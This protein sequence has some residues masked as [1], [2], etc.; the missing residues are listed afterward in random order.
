MI[1]I[2]VDNI[3]PNRFNPNVMAPEV[4]R[5]LCED[6][7][8]GGH[9][10]I[11]PITVSEKKVFYNNPEFESGK[12]VI[13]D[14]ENRWKAAKE[15][16]WS[17]IACDISALTEDLAKVV[18]YRKNKERGTIDPLREA[19]L[20]K[21]E[22][23][24]LT[25]EQVALKYGVSQPF[26]ANRLRLIKLNPEVV[27]AY[28]KPNEKFKEIQIKK[29]E[30]ELKEWKEKQPKNGWKPEKPSEEDL[31]PRGIISSSHL[32]AI[33]TLPED[34]QLSVARDIL[35]RDISAKETERL[36]QRVKEEIADDK[37]FRE[38]LAKAV[39]KTCPKCGGEPELNYDGKTF[40]C[41]GRNSEGAYTAYGCPSWDPMKTKKEIEA[42]IQ[43]S[44]SEDD[45]KRIEELKETFKEARENP[46]YVKLPETPE[47]LSNL[48]KPWLVRK[49]QEFTEV[50]KISVYGKRGSETFNI[51]FDPPS[52]GFT[53]L[54]LS[55]RFGKLEFGFNV[56]PKE[57]KRENAKS[58]VNMAWGMKP[59]EKSRES[60]RRFF[61]ETVKTERDDPLI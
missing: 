54:R 36:V 16:G 49:I 25:Q 55:F 5:S 4:F 6:M 30:T 46:S 48:V 39:T 12:Y 37:R 57:Y 22:T 18:N 8:Q 34:R 31:I 7:K 2:S 20:F 21:S 29:H 23:E 19:S 9:D 14:G 61:K 59:T 42:E 56:E 17:T 53:N 26:I 32:E 51:D 35:S 41:S 60:I 27:E 15:I 52:A 11:S 28:Q 47:E 3:E 45:L 44:K 10:V 58:R 43:E 13:V 50:D 40:K 24:S 1:E 38:L 33:S